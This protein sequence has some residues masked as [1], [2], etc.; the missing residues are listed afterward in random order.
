MNFIFALRPHEILLICVLCVLAFVF[1]PAPFNW[2]TLCGLLC[3]GAMRQRQNIRKFN[4]GAVSGH[5]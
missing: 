1:V 2:I 5:V 3:A 4:R